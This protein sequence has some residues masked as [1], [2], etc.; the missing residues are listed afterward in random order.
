MILVLTFQQKTKSKSLFDSDD[1]DDVSD[2]KRF[3]IREEFEGE[4]GRKVC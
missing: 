1:E 3:G 4:E 2:V